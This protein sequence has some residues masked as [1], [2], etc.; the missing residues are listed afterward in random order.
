MTISS[1]DKT[2]G[3]IRLA[4]TLLSV[5][6]VVAI[7]YFAQGVLIPVALALMLAFV[8]NPLVTL[9][10]RAR[11]GRIPAVLS[12]VFIAALVLA[13]LIAVI[14]VELNSLADE[15]P[16]YQTNIRSRIAMLRRASDGSP[17][18]RLRTRLEGLMQNDGA[19]HS[20]PAAPLPS[21]AANSEAP[22]ANEGL[23]AKLTGPLRAVAPAFEVLGKF[24]LA[25]ILAIFMLMKRE[26]LRNRLVS[27]LGRQN[28]TTTTKAMDDAGRRI[29]RYMMMQ[30]MINGVFGLAITLGLFLVGVPYA[31][32]WGFCAA[33]LRYIPYIG[34]WIAAFA[35]LTVSFITS[36]TWMGMV[37]VLALFF[38]LELV[39][40][41]MIEPRLYGHG[42]GVSEV[43]VLISAAFWAWLWGPVGLM[44]STPLTVCI[45]VAGKY[46]PALSFFDK[47]LGDR[48]ALRS[49]TVFLQRLLAKDLH[50]AAIV[51]QDYCGRH[52]PERSYDHL[53]VP[54]LALAMRDRASGAM[55]AEDEEFV[56]R[57]TLALVK[58][59]PRSERKEPTRSPE[60][61]AR[62]TGFPAHHQVDELS[63]QMLSELVGTEEVNFEVC[64]TRSLPSERIA[65]VV[66]DPPA[67]VLVAALAPAGLPQATYLCETLREC[68]PKLHI[69]VGFWGC[70]TGLDDVIAGL[71]KAG[72]NHV[73]TT[74]L[75]ARRHIMSW[76]DDLPS[77]QS[78]EDRIPAEVA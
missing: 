8:L 69:V 65:R 34:A 19:S 30:L 25:F 58:T 28:I 21:P 14:G 73:T 42:T 15:L 74:L 68:L 22:P 40:G 16:R 38:V 57:E 17:L 9:L 50:E 66:D 6:L 45:V 43:A 23:L 48:P 59:V 49:S 67:M 3:S 56:I 1:T 44:L 54:A 20:S 39:T 4:A 13:S 33:I 18:N 41:N 60:T 7:L 12:T 47:L 78:A 64:S 27:F 29:S 76:V 37:A 63:L 24:S 53:F 5:T 31:L 36:T 55:P 70:E 10:Q 2:T 61:I 71:R 46:V 11:M 32:L 62:I 52:A 35:P 51:I 75:G 26:D 77:S 72:A